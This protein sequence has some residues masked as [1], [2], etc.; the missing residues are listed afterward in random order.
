MAR[1]QAEGIP[2]GVVQNGADLV[3]DPHLQARSFLGVHDNPRF[4]RITLTSF[5][6]RFARAAA[7]RDCVFLDLGRD[8]DRILWD[9]LATTVRASSGCGR[10]RVL[11]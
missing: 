2:S 10:T 8:T 3:N 7:A 11:E 5:P 6:I 1:L 9:V 4:G